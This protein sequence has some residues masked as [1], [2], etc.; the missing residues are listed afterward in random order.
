MRVG[1]TVSLRLH[2][3]VGPTE[4]VGTVLAAS[5]DSL[6]VRR[7]DGSVVEL[8]VTEITAGRVVPPSPAQTV[9]VAEL[10]QVMAAGWRAAE[11]EHLG[12]WLLRAA[13]G[14]TDRANSALVVGDPGLPLNASIDRVE[15]WYD[16]RQLPPRVQLPDRAQPPGLAAEMDA[17]EWKP[18]WPTHVMTAEVGPV[19]RAGGAQGADVAVADAPD[20]AWLSAYRPDEGRD[21][22]PEH[23]IRVLLTNHPDAAFASVREGN[24]CVAIARVAIDGRWV[25]LSCVEVVDD[26]RRT[27]L[28]TAVS[29]AA[30]RWATSRGARRAYLQVTVEN[31]GARALYER[32]GFSVHHGYVYRSR[33]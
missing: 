14:F 29:V 10:H 13:G 26:R 32:L 33:D 16:D 6:T 30:L 28:A 1:D 4:V 3:A 31:T 24:R 5:A 12:D 18:S 9:D 21:G 27:G 19:L 17:R 15:R 11:V 22:A 8:A 25:G 23:V 7:R 20:D 2:T